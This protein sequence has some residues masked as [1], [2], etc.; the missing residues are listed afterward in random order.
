[1]LFLYGL[2][3]PLFYIVINNIVNDNINITIFKNKQIARTELRLIALYTAQYRE[4]IMISSSYII[5]Q[6]I[7]KNSSLIL[8]KN[9][10]QKQVCKIQ[11]NV[12]TEDVMRKPKNKNCGD[13]SFSFYDSDSSYPDEVIIYIKNE[14]YLKLKSK[15]GDIYE[16]Y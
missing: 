2:C 15:L 10:K 13:I 5:I 7:I 4:T 16:D 6:I 12:V 8:K 3:F 14:D 1:M 9:K 11:N